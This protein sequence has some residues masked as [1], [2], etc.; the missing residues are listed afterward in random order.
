MNLVVTSPFDTKPCKWRIFHP[1]AW[2]WI[3]SSSVQLDISRVRVKLVYLHLRLGK[4]I[5]NQMKVIENSP[6]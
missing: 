3:L 2:I 5:Q 4:P 1:R 6:S